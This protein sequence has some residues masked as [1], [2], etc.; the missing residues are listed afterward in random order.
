MP[1]PYIW[2]KKKH[3]NFEPKTKL[4][5]SKLWA[6]NR[7][8]NGTNFGDQKHVKIGLFRGPIAIATH[9]KKTLFCEF[10]EVRPA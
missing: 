2:H 9:P 8:K 4:K 5:L 1:A 10:F 7:V 6:K 3:P